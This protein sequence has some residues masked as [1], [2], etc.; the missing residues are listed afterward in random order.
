MKI[1]NCASHSRGLSQLCLSFMHYFK[2]LS[3]VHCSSYFNIIN[4]CVSQ[5]KNKEQ[6]DQT[7]EDPKKNKIQTMRAKFGGG[8]RAD[9]MMK[10]LKKLQKG[11]KEG[12]KVKQHD[13]NDL[14][15][16]EN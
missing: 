13:Y 8:Q 11:Y 9:I 6:E 5:T 15:D 12:L 2:A 3:Q 4:I 7:K 16:E 1:L 10:T 14:T